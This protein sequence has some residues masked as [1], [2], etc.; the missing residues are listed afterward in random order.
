MKPETEQKMSKATG[1]VQ[2]LDPSDR[3]LTVHGL[4]L[5]KTFQVADDAV[6]ATV[7]N[8]V[9]RFGDLKVGDSVVVTY[10]EQGAAEIAHRIAQT[11]AAKTEQERKAA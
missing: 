1:T 2:K 5:N 11:G 10:E 9:A 8:P 7:A 3:S 6:I 4:V